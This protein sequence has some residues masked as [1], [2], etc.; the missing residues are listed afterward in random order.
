MELGLAGY[1][2]GKQGVQIW[3]SPAL[4]TMNPVSTGIDFISD[5]RIELYSNGHRFGCRPR[6]RLCHDPYEATMPL[7]GRLFPVP[8]MAIR[9]LNRTF[10]LLR[11]DLLTELA[12]PNSYA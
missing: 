2:S 9:I 12:S 5:L 10:W 6:I 11:S 8:M 7:K 1:P 3:V 4:K